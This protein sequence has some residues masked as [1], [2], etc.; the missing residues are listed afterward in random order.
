MQTLDGF[1]MPLL[2]ALCLASTPVVLVFGYLW[3]SSPQGSEKMPRYKAMTIVSLAWLAAFLLLYLL[4]IPFGRYG[5]V[6]IFG[7]PAMLTYRY[8]VTQA[9]SKGR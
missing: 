1:R 4:G 8:F 5:L 3:A 7:I 2:L 9:G 6:L